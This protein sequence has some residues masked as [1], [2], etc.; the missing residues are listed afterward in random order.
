MIRSTRNIG[1]YKVDEGTGMTMAQSSSVQR[2]PSMEE[3]LASIRRIIEDNETSRKDDKPVATQAAN[4]PLFE[5]KS[6][7]P[8]EEV[9]ETQVFSGGEQAAVASHAVVQE[10]IFASGQQA[11]MP[12]TTEPLREPD[13]LTD[14]VAF[15]SV[16]KPAP[17]PSEPLPAETQVV[18]AEPQPE[19][20]V[21]E[22]VLEMHEKRES[23]EP[24]AEAPSEMAPKE[25]PGQAPIVSEQ[26]ER[27]VALAFSELS[28]AYEASRKK[29]LADAA[30]EM[31][32][33]MLREWLDDNLPQLVE[34]LVREEIE[35][36]ARG[37]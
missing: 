12:A 15:R 13:F 22:A 1:G 8:E 17:L 2:E 26:S 32:R 25:T 36:I 27:K 30:E 24:V 11:E 14:V 21:A 5:A 7:L 34:K 18:E 29:S 3:I 31:L 4:R 20:S 35:R 23:V 19:E 33:P 9:G 37:N 10:Q 28:E 16:T 6:S